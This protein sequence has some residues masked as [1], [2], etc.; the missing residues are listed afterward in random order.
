MEPQ[1]KF[2]EVDLEFDVVS[3]CSA[4]I[5]FTNK[6]AKSVI[7]LIKRIDSRYF[8]SLVDSK[9]DD[10]YVI[11]SFDLSANGTIVCCSL[12]C[13]MNWFQLIGV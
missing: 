10:G 2:D 5:V 7:S 12:C 13:Q 6:G 3:Y 1:H 9:E 8:S 11:L 4:I